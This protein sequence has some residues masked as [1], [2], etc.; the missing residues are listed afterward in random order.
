MARIAYA[1]ADK[2]GANKS[3]GE[4]SQGEVIWEFALVRRAKHPAELVSSNYVDIFSN[5]WRQGE[6]IV[7]VAH[8][9]EIIFVAEKLV[10]P[11]RAEARRTP[12]K[13]L[14]RTDV[15]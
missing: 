5:E 8:S 3:L 12:E 6:N 13:E 14:R 15:I 9:R 10:G 4:E 2:Q 7:E 11:V 1:A